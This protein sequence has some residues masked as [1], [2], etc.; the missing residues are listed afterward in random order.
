MAL[1]PG[2]ASM[3]SNLLFCLLLDGDTDPQQMF[4]EHLAFGDKFEAP[5]RAGWQPHANNKDPDRC[6]QIGIVSGDL[7]GHAIASFIEPVLAGLVNRPG[8]CFHAYSTNGHEDATTQ[9]LRGYFAHWNLVLGLGD[10]ALADK[11][12][13]DGIDILIDLS[14]HT[15]KNRLLTFAR[16]PAPVQISWMGYPGTTGLR[17][18]DYYFTDRFLSPHGLLD[19]QFTEKLVQ[20]PS[21]SLFQRSG[22]APQVNDLPALRNGYLTF[23]SFNRPNKISPGVVGLWSRVLHALPDSQML[24]GAMPQTESATLIG[25]FEGEGIDRSRLQFHPKTGMRGYLAL[26]HQVDICLDTF[27]YSGGT[28]TFHAMSMG[29]PTLSLTG[30]TPPSRCGA[31]SLGQVCLGDFVTK[32]HCDFI[33]RAV[34][35]SDHLTELAQLRAGLRERLNQSPVGRPAI[36]AA[37]LDRAW[38]IMW[39]RWCAGLPAQA[40]EITL[41]DLSIETSEINLKPM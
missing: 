21:A 25:W 10:D 4:A 40:F 38:R 41:Q 2:V 16:K 24:L 35:W 27:P 22:H 12:R 37:G 26:H 6:L 11:V 8:L 32:D 18:M 9:R 13:A 23:G 39:Q 20:L 34:Y 7:W 15:A 29:V 30:Q 19:D 14:G 33:G 5:L 1:Q 17:G 3:H 36:V 28:T 31:S